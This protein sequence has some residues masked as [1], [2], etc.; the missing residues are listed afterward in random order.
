[1][2]RSVL[3]LF[4]GALSTGVALGGWRT[5]RFPLK[6]GWNAFYLFVDASESTLSEVLASETDVVEVW[7]WQPAALGQGLLSDDEAVAL[8]VDEWAKWERAD[9]A[10][11]T[12]QRFR[13]NYAYLVR[14]RDGAPDRTLAI[15]GRAVAP[16]LRWQTS[17]LNLL[18]F[19]TDPA[20]PPEFGGFFAGTGLFNP[21]TAVLE[22]R[23]GPLVEGTNPRQVPNVARAPVTRG[24]AYWIDTAAFSRYQA[25]VRVAIGFGGDGLDFGVRSGISRVM[26]TNESPDPVVVTLAPENSE[27][28]VDPGSGVQV[29]SPVPLRRRVF[30]AGT[31][32]FVS[33][34]LVGP[35]TITVPAGE[36]E[37]VS[38]FVDRPALGGAAGAERASLLKVSA[39][40]QLAYL[41]VSATRTSPAGLWIGEAVIDQVGSQLVSYQRDTE[42]NTIFDPESGLPAIREDRRSD[43]AD[44]ELPGTSGSYTL[45]LLLHVGSGGAVTFLS[46]VFMGTS[47]ASGETILATDESLLDASALDTARRLSVAHLPLDVALDAGTGLAPG[48]VLGPLVLTTGPD[49]PTNPFKHNYHPDHDNLDPRFRNRLATGTESFEITR[50]ITLGVD[51]AAPDGAP[52]GWGSELLTGSYRETITGTHKDALL[53]RGRFALRKVSDIDTLLGP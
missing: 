4:L 41:P 49:E 51:A 15:K 13:A 19:P 44:A 34:P 20:A 5:E 8:N 28:P 6:A 25:P 16:R 30:D 14:L 23:G 46:E 43:E 2:I 29:G 27:S 11:A 45:R 52:L 9:V 53:T 32:A 38:L 26:L 35:T 40:G 1:M 17:G 3:L 39:P 31:Q 21:T 50:R 47:A 48:S 12:F 37:A 18:G 33:V 42:G 7:R 36:T 22:Y 10:N 24:K